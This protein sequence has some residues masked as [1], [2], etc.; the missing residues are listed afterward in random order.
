M[1]QIVISEFMDDDAVARLRA[2]HA[3]HYDPALVDDPAALA[4]IVKGADALIVRNRTQVSEE[5]LAV[6]KSLRCVGRLGVGLDNID[7]AACE[8]KGVAVYPATGA[9]NL[10]V[11]EYVITTALMLVRGA[12]QSSGDVAAGNWPRQALIGREI[13]GKVMGLVGFGG[14]AQEVAVRARAM[15][16]QIVAHDPYVPEGDPA[17]SGAVSLALE[18]LLA[19]ADVISLHVPLTDATRNLIDAD[20]LKRMKAS[21][22]LI[23]TARGGVVDEAALAEAMKSGQLGGA[24]LDVFASEPLGSDA[25]KPLAGIENLVLTPHIAG[26]TAESNVR[27]SHM[28]ADVVLAHLAAGS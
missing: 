18:D 14:I 17:W 10:A 2:A 20:A 12:Y 26:V 27:V 7:M 25:G 1:S 23:N 28:I 3:T 22:V 8:A 11:A 19:Q 13:S 6:G 21:A 4:E 5:L 15:G 9:N 24:A 16:M